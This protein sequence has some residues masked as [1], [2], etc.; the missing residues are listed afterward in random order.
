MKQY[1]NKYDNQ[2]CYYNGKTLTLNALR[3]RF[4]RLGI[5][6]STIEAKKYL[7]KNNNPIEFY[8]VYP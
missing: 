5:Q 1:N 6:H 4:K 2:L 3:K 7:L 8:D